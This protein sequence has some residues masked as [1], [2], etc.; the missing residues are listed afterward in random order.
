MCFVSTLI[1]SIFYSY[2]VSKCFTL[3]RVSIC[4][5]YKAASPVSG[6][7]SVGDDTNKHKLKHK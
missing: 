5:S 4:V 3:L 6:V 1:F 7:L 2:L